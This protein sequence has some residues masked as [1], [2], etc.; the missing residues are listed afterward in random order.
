MSGY[1]KY[2]IYSIY[3]IFTH[4]IPPGYNTDKA[5]NISYHGNIEFIFK[6]NRTILTVPYHTD[7]TQHSYIAATSEFNNF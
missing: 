3:T 4:K 5:V 7:I 1:Y 2:K 6:I